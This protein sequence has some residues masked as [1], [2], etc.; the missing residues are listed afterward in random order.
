MNDFVFGLKGT[1]HK[2]PARS[3]GICALTLAALLTDVRAA[4]VRL[5]DLDLTQVVQSF[6]PPKRNLSSG[7]K[8]ITLA[9]KTYEHGLGVCPVSVLRFVVDGKVT[10]F[11]ATVGI[12]DGAG[13]KDEK[14]GNFNHL[15]RAEFFVVADDTRIVWKSGLMEGG[16]PPTNVDVD[17]TGVKTLRLYVTGPN[18]DW[19]DHADW[20]DAKFTVDGDASSFKPYKDE[21]YVLTPPTPATPRINGARVFGV[22]PGSPF[23]FTIPATGKRPLAFTATGLP[24]GLS[25]N[26]DN[27]RITGKLAKPGTYDVGLTAN[28]ALGKDTKGFQIV[29]GDKIALTPPMGWNSYNYLGAGATE[30]IMR[31]IADTFVSKDLINHGWTYVNTDFG[32][33]SGD[34]IDPVTLALVPDPAK[35]QDFMGM[36]DY[37]HNAGLKVGLYSS[38]WI[39]GYSGFLGESADDPKRTS[40]KSGTVTVGPFTFEKEDVAQWVKWEIDYMKY[41]WCPIDIPNTERMAKALRAAPRDIVYSLSN[42]ATLQWGDDYVRL[43]NCWR[44]TG[45]IAANWSSLARIGFDNQNPWR[46][47]AGPGHWN[48]ADMMVIGHKTLLPNE[49]YTHMSLWC[50]LAAPLLLGFD[51]TTADDFIVSLLSNDE[52]L[53]VN[54]DPLGQQAARLV[55]GGDIEVWAKDMRDGS[56]AVG[57]FNRGLTNTSGTLDWS[58]LK[59][60][61]KWKARDLWRQKDLGVFDGKIAS[62]LPWHGCRLVRLWPVDAA[63]KES[64]PR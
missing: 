1:S 49:Q 44:T 42:G 25:L 13:F 17:L 57:I 22:R 24:D 34:K 9:G 19:I 64:Q 7:D 47:F 21:P 5:E 23:L 18:A 53:A 16:K 14:T 39:H 60:S 51:V 11:T 26:R 36:C 28:N 46:A 32:W 37:I 33:N 38:P 50:L 27:G 43:A 48:D 54:Q 41:D 31:S 6:S 15:G 40:F 58:D 63:A 20:A 62:D 10:R 59:I 2:I 55:S 3:A 35:Y 30:K 52:V 12:D 45:D 61:G 56:K 29:C 4:T 8:P